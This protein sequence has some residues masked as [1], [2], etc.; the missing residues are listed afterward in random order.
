[1]QVEFGGDST[2][3]LAN[4][5]SAL[6]ITNF[7]S[8][9]TGNYYSLDYL[10]VNLT[11][12]QPPPLDT[13]PPLCDDF[14]SKKPSHPSVTLTPGNDIIAVW[15]S[16]GMHL[17]LE[18]V[19][20]NMPIKSLQTCLKVNS[21]WQQIIQY[22]LDTETCNSRLIRMREFR[23]GQEWIGKNPDLRSVILAGYRIEKCFHILTD[24]KNIVVAAMAY[25][26]D[27]R[28]GM[29]KKTLVVVHS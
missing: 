9:E 10:S 27:E 5:L 19:F 20:L 17:I 14:K 21:E 28:S 3:D 22:Y 26:V 24:N 8:N 6:S 13:T 4:K 7:P 16:H 2:T 23:L 15:F 11:D 18:K 1:M 29:T 25:K 12:F